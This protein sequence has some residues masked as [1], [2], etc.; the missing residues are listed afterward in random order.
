[1]GTTISFPAGSIIFNHG[2]PGDCMFVVQSGVVEMVIGDTIVEVC[3]PNEAIGFMSVIDG[4]P[5]S[6]TAR[7]K[8]AT[9]VSIIDH[10]RFRFMVDEIPN[11]ATYIMGAMARRIRGMRQ[12]M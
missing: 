8:E 10:R 11:F 3:G 6:S 2:E 1:M 9:E 4:A 7:V 12:A 5:R